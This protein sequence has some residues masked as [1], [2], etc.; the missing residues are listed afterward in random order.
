ML[1]LPVPAYVDL[2]ELDVFWVKDMAFAARLRRRIL[3]CSF[4]LVLACRML[5]RLIRVGL[6]GLCEEI[7]GYCPVV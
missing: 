6:R 2:S 7:Q 1:R 5:L 3:V 4:T